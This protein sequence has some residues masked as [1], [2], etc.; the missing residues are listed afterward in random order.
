MRKRV[1]SL[2]LALVLSLSLVVPVQAADVPDWA[3]ESYTALEERGFYQLRTSGVISR[4]EFAALLARA[5]GASAPSSKLSAYPAVD[6]DY[7]ADSLD[8]YDARLAAAYGI[9]GG[10]IGADGLRY[11]LAR[12]AMTREQAA[13]MVCSALNFFSEKL[14]Y[15]ITPAGEPAAYRDSASISTWALP[16]AEAIASYRLMLGDTEGNFRPHETLDWP[17][18]VVLADRTLNLL[19]EGV[20]GAVSGLPL[21]SRLDWSGASYFGRGDYSV[22]RPKTGYAH[23]YFTIDNGDGTVSGLVVGSEGLTV[24]RFDAAGALAA[25]KTLPMELPIFGAFY[26]SGAHFY[27]AFGQMNESKSASAEVFRVVQY[28]REW[29]RLGAVSVNGKDSYTTE[30]FRS[31]VSRMA[32]SGDGSTLALYASRTRY[33]GHQSN[34][35]ILMNTSPF[36]VKTVMG[37]EFPSNHVSHSFG[38]FVRF[39]GSKMVTVD[40]GDAYPRSFVLQDGS[41]KLDL[42]K[43]TGSIGDNVTNAI[44]SGFEVSDSGY[45]FLGCSDPQDGRQGQPWNVFL[46]YTGKSGRASLTWLTHSTETIDCARLVKVNDSTFA[47]L[48][49]QGQDVHYQLLNGQGKAVG[50]EQ[51]LSNAVMPPTQPVVIDGDICWIQTSNEAVLKGRPILYRLSI[52]G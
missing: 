32:V 9:L 21:Q 14:G 29:N 43:I 44:G 51:V 1:L 35:T 41:R 22:S 52:D 8:L 50:T 48:W 28:D 46:A 23:G 15:P 45:L 18:A 30:P 36:R 19:N 13:K 17:S 42:L 20:L 40:H 12:E 33:D 4:E 11:S 37:Q 3:A 24:E 47:A 5:I 38:Q 39:D 2:T 34:I 49:A 26:D 25:T 27:L 7:F 6:P 31:T 10:S 16:Y